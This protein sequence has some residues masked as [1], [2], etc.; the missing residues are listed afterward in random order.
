ML[1]AIHIFLPYR[2]KI[3]HMM[4]FQNILLYLARSLGCE[5]AEFEE[6]LF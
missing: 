4:D 1:C 3:N 5:Q 6:I 2:L